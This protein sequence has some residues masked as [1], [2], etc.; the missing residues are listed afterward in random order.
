MPRSSLPVATSAAGK[1]PPE[2]TIGSFR[3]RAP[4][5]M[6]HYA[7]TEICQPSHWVQAIQEFQPGWRCAGDQNQTH[8]HVVSESGLVQVTLRPPRATAGKAK[9][10]C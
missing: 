10:A 3:V 4:L 2:H 5:T 9:G 7:S 6:P 1:P 8:Y